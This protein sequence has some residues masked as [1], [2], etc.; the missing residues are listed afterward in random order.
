MRRQ[1]RVWPNAYICINNFIMAAT[2]LKEMQ[3]CFKQLSEAEQKSVVE[4]IKTFLLGRKEESGRISI[5][6]YNR[7]IDEAMAEIDRGEFYTHEEVLLMLKE[8]K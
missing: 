2:L 1:E 7:E 8:E 4:M 5:E 3:D 6:Q